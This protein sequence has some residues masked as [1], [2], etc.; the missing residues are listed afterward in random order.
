M[1]LDRAENELSKASWKEGV[2]MV[3]PRDIPE[4]R[5]CQSHEEPYST[6]CT[7]SCYMCGTFCYLRPATETTPKQDSRARIIQQNCPGPFSVVSKPIFC[8]QTFILQHA[9]EI[10]KTCTLLQ[11]SFFRVFLTRPAVS[12]K[13]VFAFLVALP[14]SAPS[15]RRDFLGGFSRLLFT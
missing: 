5:A 15:F 2:R 11:R 13:L 7:P 9:F 8:K 12:L 6:D 4:P 14:T 10:Y 1:G 3:V